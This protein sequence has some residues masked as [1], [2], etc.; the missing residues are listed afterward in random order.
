MK[1][2]KNKLFVNIDNTRTSAMREKWQKIIDEGIDPF[3][4]KK[5]TKWIDGEIIM[6]SD[7]WYAFQNDHPYPGT[8]YQFVIPTKEFFTDSDQ[9]SKEIILDLFSIV[10]RLKRKYG[11]VG[12]GLSMRFGETK[13]SGGSVMHMHAQLT[14]PEDG[15]SIAVWFGSKHK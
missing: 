15:K 9:L 8:K 10:K 14:V 4:P 6:A 13:L 7:H 1:K 5:V 11:I 3:D 12:G 2:R